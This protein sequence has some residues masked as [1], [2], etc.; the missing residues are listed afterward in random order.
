MFAGTLGRPPARMAAGRHAWRSMSL[1]PRSPASPLQRADVDL[2]FDAR[3][4]EHRAARHR[5]FR[6]RERRGQGQHRYQH[7]GPA[8]HRHARPRCPR[9]ST[10]SPRC[11]TR[12]HLRRRVELR[13]SAARFLPGQAAGIAR[14]R[15]AGGPAAGTPAGAKFKISGSAGTFALDLQGDAGM[16]GDASAFTDLA[17][18]GAAKLDLAGR[19][20]AQDGGALVAARRARPAGRGRQGRRAGSTSRRPEPPTTR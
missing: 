9:R 1:A 2:R 18:L 8:R 13:R 19:L 10:G 20:D 12:S 5:R 15:C 16:A 3:A 11:S 4:L 7:A 14:R 6:R 17:K